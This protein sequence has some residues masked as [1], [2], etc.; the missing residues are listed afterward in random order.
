MLCEIVLCEIVLCKI[1]LCAGVGL[2]WQ[3]VG[4]I[5]VS[6]AGWTALAGDGGRH[7][8]QYWPDS[9]LTVHQ[10]VRVRQPVDNM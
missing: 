8:D 6:V 2:L 1:V 5:C 10:C 7:S 4:V 9:V 3:C